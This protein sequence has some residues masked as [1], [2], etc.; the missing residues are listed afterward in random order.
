MAD[1]KKFLLTEGDLA[2]AWYNVIPDLPS[3]PPPPLHPGTGGPLGPADLAPLFPMEIIQQEVSGERWVSIPGEV[4]D[5]YRMWRPTPLY[6]ADRLE[7]ALELP[8][9]TLAAT[10]TVDGDIIVCT[11][12]DP[13]ASPQ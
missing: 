12:V 5:V 10:G 8:A 6:R 1:P 13:W 4:Q 3:P 7:R 9:G 2:E 11:E